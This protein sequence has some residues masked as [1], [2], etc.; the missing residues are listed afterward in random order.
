[1]DSHCIHSKSN[2]EA[3]MDN[4]ESLRLLKYLRISCTH[5]LGLLKEHG[6]LL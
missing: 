2:Q 1:M 4:T 6:D 5:E 3:S